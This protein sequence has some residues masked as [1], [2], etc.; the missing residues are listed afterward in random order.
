[1][2]IQ[3]SSNIAKKRGRDMFIVFGHHMA[4][5]TPRPFWTRSCCNLIC[6]ITLIIDI[7]D[8]IVTPCFD[9]LAIMQSPYT[10]DTSSQHR[11]A[12]RFKG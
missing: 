12:L 1:M 5:A 10:K 2:F 8:K 11:Y 6:S 3:S 9:S 7:Y 4:R